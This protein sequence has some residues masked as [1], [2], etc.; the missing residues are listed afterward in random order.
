VRQVVATSRPAAEWF[1]C[2]GVAVRVAHHCASHPRPHD[3]LESDA[4]TSFAPTASEKVDHLF[5]ELRRTR[6]SG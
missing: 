4:R 5:A 6:Q 2:D 3:G 1:N